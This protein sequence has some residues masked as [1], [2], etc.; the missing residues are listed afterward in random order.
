MVRIWVN[1][2]FDV[3]HIGHIE[4]LKFAASFG[5][6]MVGID[7]DER[8]KML[9]GETRPINSLENRLKF[10]QSI[11]YVHSTTSYS[12]SEELRQEIAKWKPDAM[13]IGEEY[14]YKDI[15]G[16]ELIETIILY[17]IIR[18]ISSTEILKKIKN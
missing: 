5:Q 13:V 6:V 1:G 2:C 7:T 9:K 4:L 3:L 11:K 10:L 16:A 15:I 18:G 8:V 14:A 17:P 12:N